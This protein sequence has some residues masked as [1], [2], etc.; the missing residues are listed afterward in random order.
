[1]K[2]KWNYFWKYWWSSEL[3]GH[4]KLNYPNSLVQF[5]LSHF[6]RLYSL[7]FKYCFHHSLPLIKDNLLHLLPQT[8]CFSSSSNRMYPLPQLKPVLIACIPS[9]PNYR[10]YP[11][12]PQLLYRLYPPPPPPPTTTCIPLLQIQIDTECIPPCQLQPV[13]HPSPLTTK[14]VSP[15]RQITACIPFL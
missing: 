1:M 10:L 9:S 11:H 14:L 2:G 13:S 5:S 12:R 8:Q 3:E 4:I 15:F 6:L 7:L